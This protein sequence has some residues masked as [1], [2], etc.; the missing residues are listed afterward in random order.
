MQT[1]SAQF[2]LILLIN[3]S[4]NLFQSLLTATNSILYIYTLERH[5]KGKTSFSAP[6]HLLSLSME[7]HWKNKQHSSKKCSLSCCFD[8]DGAVCCLTFC[9]KI[10]HRYLFGLRSEGC[11]CY[12]IRLTSFLL[13]WNYSVNYCALWMGI[14][15]SLK[16]PLPSG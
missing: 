2:V 14:G 3:F 6:C 7:L 11:E 8:D 1:L 13:S 16:R 12:C 9:F 5:I 10:S 4:H 15:S